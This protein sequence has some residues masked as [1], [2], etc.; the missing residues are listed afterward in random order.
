MMAQAELSAAQRKKQ[1]DKEKEK[2]QDAF[3]ENTKLQGKR[4]AGLESLFAPPQYVFHGGLEEAC[5]DGEKKGKWIIVNLISGTDFASQ[6]LNRD[7]WANG[8]V[9]VLIEGYYILWQCYPD[10]EEGKAFMERYQAQEAPFVGLID[11]RT[12]QLVHRMSL[13][14]WK[15]ADGDWNA[16]RVSDSLWGWVEKHEHDLS[17]GSPAKP[18]AVSGGVSAGA[19]SGAAVPAAP[20]PTAP[21]PP[22]AVAAGSGDADIDAAVAMSLDDDAELAAAIAMSREQAAPAEAAAASAPA[23]APAWRPRFDLSAL[24]GDT[25]EHT[26]RLRWRLTDGQTA[27][28]M[29]LPTA[30]VG[31]VYDFARERVEEG[32]ARGFD[33]CA[34]F[35]PRPLPD[36]DAE[37]VGGR[38][39]S[40]EMLQMRWK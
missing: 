25:P 40:G 35:P 19:A 32:R 4:Q 12:R 3:K 6:T 28:A 5:D 24:V 29:L 15:R 22:A 10:T 27:E 21:V 1:K 30:P 38:K 16:E 14:R 13:D 2:V 26:I 20:A 17:P 23:P 31:A 37:T 11:P 39:L 8:Q 36:T 9:S 34:G 7:V 18:P 33:L